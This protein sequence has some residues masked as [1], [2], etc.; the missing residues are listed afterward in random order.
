M[1]DRVALRLYLPAK[2]ARVMWLLKG[3]VERFRRLGASLVA[4]VSCH[5][6]SW[7][8]GPT[9]KPALKQA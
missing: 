3:L 7:R 2:R 8:T 6:K 4:R 5:G 1:V 9:W